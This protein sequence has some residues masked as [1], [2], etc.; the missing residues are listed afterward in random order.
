MFNLND[1]LLGLWISK[2]NFPLGLVRL[3]LALTFPSS[4][5]L[6]VKAGLE[7]V[8]APETGLRL[9]PGPVMV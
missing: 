1:G 7:T 5:S 2:V 3:L 6:R 4:E 8:A 9:G